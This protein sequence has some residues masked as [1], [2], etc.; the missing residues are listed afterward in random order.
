MM[1]RRV[2]ACCFAVAVATSACGGPE[3]APSVGPVV[4][5]FEDDTLS[6]EYPSNWNALVPES[7]DPALVLLSTEPL[8]TTEPRIEK[9][10]S[11]GVYIAWTTIATAP[12]PT[13]DPSFS[14]EVTVGG[15]PATA[16]PRRRQMAIAQVSRETSC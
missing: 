12:S 15:R 8:A 3:P 16:L 4:S 2:I 1:V 5:T 10:G 9:L 14:S 11:D 13:P 6:F 7:G